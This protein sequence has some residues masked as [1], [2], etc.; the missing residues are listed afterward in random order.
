[1][2]VGDPQKTLPSTCHQQHV[3]RLHLLFPSRH[4]ASHLSL[5]LARSLPLPVSLAFSRA[6]TAPFIHAPFVAKVYSGDR[7]SPPRYCSIW[8]QNEMASNPHHTSVSQG[9]CHKLSIEPNEGSHNHRRRPRPGKVQRRRLR[10][11]T[12][13]YLWGCSACSGSPSPG[14]I[15]EAR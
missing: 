9:R 15:F 13:L 8:E 5:S 4:P 12:S 6:H 3:Y 10:T 7:H 14:S 11:G 1:M 2:V